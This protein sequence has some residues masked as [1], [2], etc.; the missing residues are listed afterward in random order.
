MMLAPPLWIGLLVAAVAGLIAGGYVNWATYTLA[1][2]RRPISPWAPRHERAPTRTLS[3]RLP[4]WGWLGLRR[5]ADIHGAGFWRRP[6]AVELLMALAWVALY[7]WEVDRQGLLHH[8]FEA[9]IGRPLPAGRFAAPAWTTLATF[10]SHA[11]LLTLMAAASLIDFDEKT[12]PDGVTTPGTLLA[13]A[14]AAALPMSL[15]PHVAERMAPP[16]AGVVIQLPAGAAAQMKGAALY[17]E[18]LSLAAPNEWPAWLAGAPNGVSLTIGLA[19]FA[20]WWVALT[21]RIMRWRRGMFFGLRVLAARSL[22]ELLRP[23]SA[24]IGLV[25]FVAIAAVWYRGG[26]SWL[27]LLTA[28]VGMVGGGAMV[29]AVRIVGSAALRKEAMGFG[30]VTLMMMIGAFL[31]W[32]PTIFI[33]FM[34]PFAGLLIGVTQMILRRDDVIPY[35]PFLCLAAAAVTIWWAWFWNQDPH[36][37]Q[38]IFELGWLLPMVLALGVVML[39]AMLVIWRNIKEAIF[40]VEYE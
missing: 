14:L 38:A 2:N 9:M 22:R 23:R 15:L 26:E 33:F 28:L 25:G 24:L 1:W 10:L 17:V 4:L 40:G 6:F 19:C 39:G 36:G 21:P 8:Q 16:L 31:G 32:Q 18:P 5:E 12:I 35:G 29:W 3:D 13:L 30:D 7:W 11:I 34:A 20:L 27:G 37:F